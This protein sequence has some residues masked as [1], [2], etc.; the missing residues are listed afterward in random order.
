MQIPLM[1]SALYIFLV[2]ISASCMAE[3]GTPPAG[4]LN[5]MKL[6]SAGHTGCPP[7]QIE[8]SNIAMRHDLG[9]D[10]WGGLWSAAG[11]AKLY[12]C[13][14]AITNNSESFSCAPVPSK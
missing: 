1:K 12:L 6:V 2:G 10:L 13:T 14:A 7:E 5:M 9:S 4:V 3:T 11:N 8:L